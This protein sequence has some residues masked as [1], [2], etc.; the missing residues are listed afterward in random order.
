MK[1]MIRIKSIPD[2][3]S[4]T[5]MYVAIFFLFNVSSNGRLLYTVFMSIQV[6][7]GEPYYTTKKHNGA[8]YLYAQIKLIRFV[9]LKKTDLNADICYLLC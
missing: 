1:S 6:E 3:S 4:P 2:T 7:F 8:L 9:S 5:E